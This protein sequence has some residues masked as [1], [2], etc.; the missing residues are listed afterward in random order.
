[1]SIWLAI[2]VIFE[3][4]VCVVA[5]F[6]KHTPPFGLALRKVRELRKEHHVVTAP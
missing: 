3:A 5:V 6:P 2:M 4:I 1:M